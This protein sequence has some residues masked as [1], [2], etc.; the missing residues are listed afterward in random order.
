[1]ESIGIGWLKRIDLC[2]GDDMP[3]CYVIRERTTV[4]WVRNLLP[5][6]P[7]TVEAMITWFDMLLPGGRSQF[8]VWCEDLSDVTWLVYAD[9]SQNRLFFDPRHPTAAAHPAP[10]ADLQPSPLATRRPTR[11]SPPPRPA[12]EPITVQRRAPSNT[13]VIMVTGQ[14]IV[15]GRA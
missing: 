1:M 14:E 12:V 2:H 3:S 13:G 6:T 7:L 4:R 5:H 10:P 15:L 8:G 9:G 11:R